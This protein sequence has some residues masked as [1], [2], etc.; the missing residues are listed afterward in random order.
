MKQDYLLSRLIC[1]YVMLSWK[2]P[3]ESMLEVAA[4]ITGLVEKNSEELCDLLEMGAERKG[5]PRRSSTTE[6][7]VK[8]GN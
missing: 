6:R 2:V 7:E 3:R 4:G 1:F 8:L 5:G